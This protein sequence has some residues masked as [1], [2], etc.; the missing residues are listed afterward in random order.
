MAR[1]HTTSPTDGYHNSKNDST[2]WVDSVKIA[3]GASNIYR[4][5]IKKKNMSATY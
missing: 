1:Q 5:T 4:D 3:A 2:T